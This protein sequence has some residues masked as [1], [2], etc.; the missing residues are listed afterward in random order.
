[1]DSC[2]FYRLASHE[3]KLKMPHDIQAFNEVEELM[4]VL[5]MKE[6]SLSGRSLLLVT[7][8]EKHQAGGAGDDDFFDCEG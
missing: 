4:G 6:F 8:Q 7:L 3:L 2:I 1:M 5:T